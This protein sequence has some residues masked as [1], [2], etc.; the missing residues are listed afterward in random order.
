[1]TM[2]SPLRRLGGASNPLRLSTLLLN[3]GAR[4]P[5]PARPPT[6]TA[7]TS[8]AQDVVVPLRGSARCWAITSLGFRSVNVD[9]DP[10]RR[11]S[12]GQRALAK[13]RAG[14]SPHERPDAEITLT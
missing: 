9:L 11:E 2:D 13:V 3:R 7:R 12:P 4:A 5:R 6:T 14:E 1:M 8:W 10:G